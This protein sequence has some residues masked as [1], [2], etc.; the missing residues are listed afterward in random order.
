MLQTII[1]PCFLINYALNKASIKFS[2][3]KWRAKA[4]RLEQE[5]SN[6]LN[7][8]LKSCFK[9]RLVQRVMQFFSKRAVNQSIQHKTQIMLRK[10]IL[11]K[12]K[13][14]YPKTKWTPD[15]AILAYFFPSIFVFYSSLCFCVFVFSMSCVRVLCFVVAVVLLDCVIGVCT[16]IPTKTTQEIYS[17]IFCTI[18]SAL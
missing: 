14:K 13:F 4:E 17:Q 5:W 10:L 12:Y 3:L 16:L 9:G 15:G 7:T 11:L 8:I 18:T 1:K 2:V 6:Q